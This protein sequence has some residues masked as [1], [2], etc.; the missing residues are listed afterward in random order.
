MDKTHAKKM[1]PDK[2]M[3]PGA[4]R[5]ILVNHKFN[6]TRGRQVPATVWPRD[7]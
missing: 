2:K 4:G 6:L 5:R 1:S 3:S 7:K